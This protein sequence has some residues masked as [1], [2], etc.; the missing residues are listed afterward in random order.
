MSN[1]LTIT[2]PCSY[3]ILFVAWAFSMAAWTI[4]WRRYLQ[5]ANIVQHLVHPSPCFECL[6]KTIF[7][8]KL[9]ELIAD[10]TRLYPQAV[11]PEEISIFLCED[12][13]S[14]KFTIDGKND[15]ELLGRNRKTILH[16]AVEQNNEPLVLWLRRLDFDM[17]VLDSKGRT[18]LDIANEANMT[19]MQNLLRS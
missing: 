10:G 7:P 17:T 18:A 3:A 9:S 1:I 4:C 8:S 5:L 16:V 11:E 15:W 2:C 6:N 13:K 12:L 19:S 14:G